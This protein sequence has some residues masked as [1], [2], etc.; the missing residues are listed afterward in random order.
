[1]CRESLTQFLRHGYIPAP[2]S[3]Y[4]GVFK[5][6]PGCL[7]T[8]RMPIP[9]AAPAAP[10]RPPHQDGSLAIRRWWSMSEVVQSCAAQPFTQESDALDELESHLRR[11]V[12]LQSLADVPLGAFL[13]GGIDS[14]LIAAL[15]QTQSARPVKTFTVGFEDKAFD[16]S[17]F[18]RAVAEHL[19]TDHS[20]LF[21]TARD[22]QQVIPMLPDIYDE[23]F[24][25]SSQI[26]T[27]LVCRAARQ[28]VT[29]ALS[30]D[31]GDELFGGY[32]RYFWGPRVWDKIGWM[33]FALRAGM[34]HAIRAVPVKHWDAMGDLFTTLA[35]KRHAPFR[36]GQKAHKLA[37]RLN[38][39]RTLDDLYLSLVSEWPNPESLLSGPD[40][41]REPRGALWDPLPTS[42]MH[43]GKLRMMYRDTVTY[44][45]DDI[46]CKVDRAAM[47]VSLET[48][49][50]FLDHRVVEAAWRLPLSMKIRGT[51]GK[52]ALRKILYKYVP[53]ALIERPKAGFGVPIG[54]WLRGP[55]RGWAD[56]LLEPARLR[57]EGYLDPAPITAA[58]NEHLRGRHDWTV[59]LWSILMFQAWLER[60]GR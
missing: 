40:P 49:V 55:L 18:S 10:P 23:P 56:A 45:P 19:G 33:P 41:I 53:Q 24:A 20:E 4:Q 46:L 26:P 44:L 52:W 57:R 50:P 7:L 47:S 39:V 17:P 42:G 34:G 36:V 9:T 51:Q 11:A 30:G 5:L 29:V 35:R 12:K 22:A 32:N 28:H 13:S 54:E 16:E 3:I 21:V 25:D 27:Y 59:R 37:A 6:E 48:R 38:E 1:V 43:D 31:A 8:L 60:N 15:M 2:R 58:W 14:S